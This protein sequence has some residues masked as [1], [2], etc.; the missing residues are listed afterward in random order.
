MQ[1]GWILV[2][3]DEQEILDFLRAML[4]S[5][6]FQVD[7]FAG[8]APLL[9]MLQEQRDA[10]PDL[11][12]LDVKMPGTDGME[13][14]RRLRV[15]QPQLPVV[16]MSA[17]ATVR[18]AVDCMKQ[19]AHDYL[20]KPFFADELFALVDKIIERN[21]LVTENRSL[22]AEIRRRFDP[23]QVIFRSSAFRKVVD[24]ARKVAP[25][26]ASV[27]I[28]G[29]SGV[30]KELVAST[31]HYSSRRNEERFL[32]INCA[33]LTDTLLESQL[34]GYIKGAFTGAA[35]N[36]RGLVEEADGGTLFLDEIGDI[37]A[38]LQ[39]K[40]LRVLQE[41]EFIPVGSTKVRKADVRFIAA[42]NK[43]LEAEVR[44]GN[45][46]EDLFY[47]LNVVTLK[48]PPLR[49]RKD[50]VPPLAQFFIK[51]Y[52]P[53]GDQGI[54]SEALSL[55]VSYHW[56]G[57]VRELENVIEM[58]TI[59]AEGDVID[60]AHLPVKISE[61]GPVEFSLPGEQLSLEDVE[62]LY[63]EQ[64]Y[65]QTGYHKLRTSGILGIARKTLDRKIKQYNITK[66][67]GGR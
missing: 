29:E 2:C 52:S 34:F 67:Q 9:K 18:G 1:Q 24:L 65:R 23:D 32:T 37:S 4:E 10:Q 11:V 64:V 49:E 7:T 31:I 55:L 8:G 54:T 22:K 16:M 3:D 36:H 21:R 35:A 66:E 45:F 28:Q 57:N 39:A 13:V 27:L 47:R 30:G 53:R 59:L 50:D 44:L 60:V 5:R 41:K 17:F 14:L 58:A 43:D 61:G 26:E 40:L 25:S 19:G 38:A 46:R 62:R 20:I 33:A 42:T 48:V 6:G 63:I 51:K 15:M 56:P 12:L